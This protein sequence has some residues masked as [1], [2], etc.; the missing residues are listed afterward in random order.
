MAFETFTRHQYK[1]YKTLVLFTITLSVTA[2]LTPV[3]YE[4]VSLPQTNALTQVTQTDEATHASITALTQALCQLSPT[5]KTEEAAILAQEA[6]NYPMHLANIW[7]ISSPPLLH[8]LMRNSG[9]REY[10]LCIDW[11]YAM[12]QRMRGLELNSFDWHWGIA[13]QG[14]EWR[15]HS[16]LVVTAK[17]APFTQ[18]IILDPWRNSGRL[19]WSAVNN[20]TKYNWQPYTEPEGWTPSH[21]ESF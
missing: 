14:S 9:K 6:H 12:R 13:N 18:G 5:I 2:C 7:Q 21:L 3:R 11:T 20:D 4:G 17:N 1:Y 19:F 8:N 16:T 10:G 15:E